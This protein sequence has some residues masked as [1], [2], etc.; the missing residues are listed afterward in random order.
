MAAREAFGPNLRRQRMQRG[1]SLDWIAQETKVHVAMWT[2]LEK[3][4]FSKWPTG[5]YARAYV[6]SYAQMIGADPEATVDE[7]CRLF[8]NGDR[9]AERLIRGQAE[10]VNHPIAWQEHVPADLDRRSGRDVT[11]PRRSV[12]LSTMQRCVS[13]LL[14]M[15]RA[16]WARR[17]DGSKK[18]ATSPIS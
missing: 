9:R 5:I 10:I 7:F 3:N 1:V 16:L 15:P 8:P 4:D 18:S 17:A 11:R 12:V 13:R 6:R 2:A 14:S